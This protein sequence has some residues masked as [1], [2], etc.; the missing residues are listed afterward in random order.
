MVT[1]TRE[2]EQEKTKQET[3]A[4]IA[5][6]YEGQPGMA[7]YSPGALITMGIL[8][9][10]FGIAAL[11]LPAATSTLLVVLLG[12]ILMVSGVIEFV[13]SFSKRSAGRFFYGILAMVAGALV[14]AH[15]LF[16]LAF[17]TLLVS[18]FFIMAGI[19]QLAGYSESGSAIAGGIINIILGTILL[20]NLPEASLVA[21]AILIGINVIFA[22]FATMSLGFRRKNM[23]KTV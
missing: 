13:G 1:A 21:I 20:F 2:R 5:G 11:A 8:E 23:A 3:Q 4:K 15:P 6:A 18:I 16:N 14:I 17:L 7:A 12:G 9:I 19:A 10:L 22:G